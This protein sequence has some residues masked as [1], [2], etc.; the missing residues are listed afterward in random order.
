MIGVGDCSWTVLGPQHLHQ[1]IVDRLPVLLGQSEGCQ[2][3]KGGA[4]FSKL[5]VR[6]AFRVKLALFGREHWVASERDH[7][8][9]GR[10][11]L[12]RRRYVSI[13]AWIGSTGLSRLNNDV[14]GVLCEPEGFPETG[15]KVLYRGEANGAPGL[16]ALAIESVRGQCQS[17][18]VSHAAGTGLDRLRVRIEAVVPA[19][20]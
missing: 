10:D 8:R 14:I 18:S 20:I 7:E 13:N 5:R 6:D 17:C 3:T 19:W 12:E 11:A 16:L 1:D 9:F 4:D 15:D 2:V